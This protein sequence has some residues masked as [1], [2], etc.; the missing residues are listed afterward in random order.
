MDDLESRA[1]DATIEALWPEIERQGTA[2]NQMFSE[3]GLQVGTASVIALLLIW[4]ESAQRDGMDKASAHAL[5]DK[6]FDTP[7]IEEVK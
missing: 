3:A 5:L 1:L 6:F 2:L 4:C 7:A